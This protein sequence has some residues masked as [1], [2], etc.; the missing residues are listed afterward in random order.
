MEKET[1]IEKLRDEITELQLENMR[2]ETE[3]SAQFKEIDIKNE[4][5]TQLEKENQLLKDR[6]HQITIQ[7]QNLRTQLQ[8]QTQINILKSQRSS[9]T[10]LIDQV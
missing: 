1:E 9:I 5:I 6:L 10:V 2:T 7:C 8:K 3:H 4:I